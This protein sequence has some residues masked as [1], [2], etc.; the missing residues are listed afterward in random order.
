MDISFKAII[1][2]IAEWQS[3]VQ[4]DKGIAP[5][6]YRQALFRITG[7]GSHEGIGERGSNL[8]E[9]T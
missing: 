1:P 2:Y 7:I 6:E 8:Q 3:N 5:S 9:V 4:C